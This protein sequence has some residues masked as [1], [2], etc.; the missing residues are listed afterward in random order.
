MGN[1]LQSEFAVQARVLEKAGLSLL[2][3][4]THDSLRSITVL[5]DYMQLDAIN[6]I[7]QYAVH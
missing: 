3:S 6:T 7:S 2:I 5:C 4:R 1:S